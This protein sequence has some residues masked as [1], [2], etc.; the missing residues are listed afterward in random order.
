MSKISDEVGLGVFQVI[1]RG[2]PTEKVW[3]VLQIKIREPN[4]FLSVSDVVH[5]SSDDGLG[6]FREMSMGPNRIKENIYSD[7]QNLEVKFVV[8]HE[9]NEHVNKIYI[10]PETSVRT[11]EF[12]KRDSTT[13][14]RIHWAVP[15]K[16]ALEGIQKCLEMARKINEENEDAKARIH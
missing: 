3:Q 7:K 10:D 12:Y 14:E 15:K 8:I 1:E 13:K 4:L 9:N 2:I 5:R 11:L 6:T 16:V